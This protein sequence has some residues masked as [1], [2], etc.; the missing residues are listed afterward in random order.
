[1]SKPFFIAWSLLWSLC[2]S[3]KSEK[4]FVLDPKIYGTKRQIRLECSCKTSKCS[5]IFFFYPPF[6]KFFDLACKPHL[7]I[8]NYRWRN[9]TCL[10]HSPKLGPSHAQFFNHVVNFQKFLFLF[11]CRRILLGFNVHWITWLQRVVANAAAFNLV[12][13][14]VQQHPG[15]TMRACWDLH[16]L[17]FEVFRDNPCRWKIEV[18]E[19]VGML[20]GIKGGY[21]CLDLIIGRLTRCHS[22]ANRKQRSVF[23]FAST[24]SQTT[25]WKLDWA[26]TG[27]TSI[28]LSIGLS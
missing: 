14:C 1:M 20:I 9:L 26:W 2:F 3:L 5:D 15:T 10:P 11:F 7:W 22:I 4:N 17:I 13:S 28:Q 25:C 24:S 19:W 27:W 18:S 8:S 16:F 21:H 6:I 12:F 23:V